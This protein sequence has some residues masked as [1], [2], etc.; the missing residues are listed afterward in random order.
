MRWR[1][2]MI[3]K[4]RRRQI[5]VKKSGTEAA[6]KSHNLKIADALIAASAVQNQAA[7]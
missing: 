2:V 1:V 3:C 6:G 5:Q 4:R 7:L